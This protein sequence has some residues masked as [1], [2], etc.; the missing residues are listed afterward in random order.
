MKNQPPLCKTNIASGMAR[1]S[2]HNFSTC[3]FSFFFFP[4]SFFRIRIYELPLVYFSKCRWKEFV[5][6]A[7]VPAQK[8]CR[9][10]Q[11]N[12]PQLKSAGLVLKPVRQEHTPSTHTLKWAVQGFFNIS[13]APPA[14][15]GWAT[16]S[17]LTTRN[18][19]ST[20][21]NGQS[22]LCSGQST[23][24]S[25]R[26]T[27]CNGQL[28]L[29]NGQSTLCSGQSTLCNGQLTMCN[30]P[31][32]L[33]SGRS[34]MCN[35]QSTMCNGRLTLCNGPSTLCTGRSTLCNGQSTVCNSQPTVCNSQHCVT[36][37]QHCVRVS[38]QGVTVS[39]HYVTAN[40]IQQSINK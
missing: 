21:C 27:L 14:R 12:S 8:P 25:S 39:Q 38:Q 35:S 20:L 36:V 22:T 9:G 13:H 32:T 15:P 31:S 7:S 2:C 33:C 16:V 30:S 28:T 23:L 10:L 6:N 26:S 24:C 34:T 1:Q 3:F 37:S 11:E 5:R 19:Q 29:C 17:Q 40:T 18:G 4:S